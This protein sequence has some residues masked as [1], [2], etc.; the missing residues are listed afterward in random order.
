MR[1]SAV[2]IVPLSGRVVGVDLGTR[3]IGV[4]ISDAG[5][6]VA[7]GLTVVVRSGDL[8]A[9]HRALAALAAQ[10]EAVAVVVGLP[11]SL[12]GSV[13]PAAQ[14]VRQEVESLRTVVGV[15]VEVIDE[16][17]TTAAANRALQATGHS[18]RRTRRVVDQ[19]AA[20]VILQSWLDRRQVG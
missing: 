5:Q 3:R 7:T 10:E 4:A 1:S 14:G 8:G 2:A 19:V 17:F 9:D 11:T 15:P 18:A 12:D 16:R 13:G 6:R 20:A